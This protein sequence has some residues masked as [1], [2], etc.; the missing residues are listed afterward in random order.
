MGRSAIRLLFL[1][2]AAVIV[3][4]LVVSLTW[5]RPATLRWSTLPARVE[6]A[7]RFGAASAYDPSLKALVVFGGMCAGEGGRLAP[8]SDTWILSRGTWHR[9]A[10][11]LHPP[12]VRY[13]SMGYDG[14]SRQLILF[15]GEGATGAN[16]QTWLL[17]K[18][19]WSELHPRLSPGER[20]GAAIAFDPRYRQLLLFGGCP[21]PGTTRIPPCNNVG[22]WVWTGRDWRRL[23][24]KEHPPAM[25]SPS[26]AYDPA[27]G[28]VVLFGGQLA[29]LN[30]GEWDARTLWSWSGRNWTRGST[31]YV[32]AAR[33][34][35][36]MSYDPSLHGLVLF[37]GEGNSS[38]MSDTWKWSHGAWRRLKLRGPSRRLGTAAGYDPQEDGL[39]V[40]GG[41][42]T[43][44]AG[45]EFKVFGDTW[46][47]KK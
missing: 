22:T 4:V 23:A 1:L 7:A 26:M 20:S 40:F 21:D 16:S 30:Q 15:G 2:G 43:Q 27:V 35:A 29:A 32:P 13:A 11:K 37:G 24:T 12:P 5:P 46:V 45:T 3:A 10:F 19:G 25:M 38:V 44:L 34:S 9:L 8:C 31:Q 41:E 18:R 39:I 47:L 28:R 14:R 42:W 17:T 33:D 36:V 6:P